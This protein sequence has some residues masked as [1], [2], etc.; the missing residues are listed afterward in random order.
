MDASFPNFNLDLDLTLEQQFKIKLF[1]KSIEAMEPAE[2][3]S[4][5]LE[6]SRLLM[7]KDNIIRG[8]M[9]SE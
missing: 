8:L 3:Q 4:L 5:L 1:E 9:K 6:A 2:A 7:I